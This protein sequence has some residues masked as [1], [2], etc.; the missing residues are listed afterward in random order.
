[1]TTTSAAPASVAIPSASSR[2]LRIWRLHFANPAV[3]LW[4]PLLIL[5]FI[6]VINGVIWWLVAMN[7]TT[8]DRADVAEGTQWSGASFFVIV[9]M[10]VVAIQAMNAT[11]ALALGFGSTRRDYYLGSGLAFVTLAAGWSILFGLLG[12]LE[13]VTDGWGLNGVMFSA[14]YFGDD[15]PLLRVLFVFLLFLLSMFV[16]A[17]SGALFVRWKSRGVLGLWITVATVIV[18]TAA[19][20]TL[21][22]GWPAAW[23]FLTGIGL[24]GVYLLTLIPTA[25]AATAGFFVLRR[26]TPPGS[27][28]S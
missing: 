23:E 25:A 15:G 16:G 17:L 1:M 9:Y 10:M 7:T 24:G 4:T 22:D 18:A 27:A 6:F 28:A 21:S 14:V 19:V 3:V 20:L 8:A 13:E 11:F 12:F 26:A 5:G 2:I